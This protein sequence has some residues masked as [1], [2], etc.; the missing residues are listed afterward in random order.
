MSATITIPE[1]VKSSKECIMVPCVYDCASAR[2]AELAGYKAILLSG[3]EV[4]E[5]LGGI[6]EDCLTEDELLFMAE[7]ICRFSPLPLIVDC[8][9]FGDSA[10]CVNRFSEKFA[11]AGAMALLIEDGGA[12]GF[13]SKEEFFANIKAAVAGCEG[14]DC[15]VMGR[16]NM[17]I[18]SEEDRKEIADRLN[19][20]LKLGAYMVMPCGLNNSADTEILGRMIH[21]PKCYPDQNTHHGVPEVVNEEIYQWGYSMVSFHYALKVAMES[22]IRYGKLDLQAGNN[23]PSNDLAFDNG[24]TGHSALPMFDMQGIFDR[25]AQ[26]TGVRKIFRVPGVKEDD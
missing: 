2:A 10:R 24:V 11:R 23:K 9:C 3:G 20:A 8:G 22:M 21:G 25:E 14:T 18:Q 19:G 4:G 16:S 6:M 15:I 17:P 5:V 12:D 26:F 7:H 1:L 13:L